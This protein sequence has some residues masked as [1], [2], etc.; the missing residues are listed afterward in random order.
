MWSHAAPTASPRYS[1]PVVVAAAIERAVQLPGA[2]AALL[3]G[4]LSLET[5]RQPPAQAGILL[6]TPS[7]LT[8]LVDIAG[9]ATLPRA[10]RLSQ[11]MIYLAASPNGASAVSVADKM[12]RQMLEEALKVDLGTNISLREQHVAK[13]RP[14]E[15][16][17]PLPLGPGG[18]T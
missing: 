9:L 11:F 1:E 14:S 4:E 18:R 17:P 5:S 12:T 8:E 13:Q 7:D 6:E 15:L 3:S 2:L 16:V 10:Q